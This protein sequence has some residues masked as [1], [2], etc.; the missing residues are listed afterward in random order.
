MQPWRAR[1]LTYQATLSHG[2]SLTEEAHSTYCTSSWPE[3]VWNGTAASANVGGC[4]GW[5]WPPAVTPPCMPQAAVQ[6]HTDYTICGHIS[7]Q[8]FKRGEQPSTE[9]DTPWMSCMRRTLA[10]LAAGGPPLER[11]A[12]PL[13]LVCHQVPELCSQCDHPEGM[14]G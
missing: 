11:R 3:R 5:Q 6:P 7:M 1:P 9:I 10:E 8:L 4:G 12:P 2:D 14:K 13:P